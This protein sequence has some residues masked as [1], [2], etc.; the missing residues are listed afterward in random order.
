[1]KLLCHS[2]LPKSGFRYLSC[3]NCDKKSVA[4]LYVRMWQLFL[5]FITLYLPDS[6][7]AKVCL[8][9]MTLNMASYYFVVFESY[10]FQA[11]KKVLQLL[12]Y[13]T[14]ILNSID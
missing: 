13:F 12:G 7:T 3:T 2:S 10:C 4:V 14:V 1:M 6:F 9:E 5:A 8:E 11:F